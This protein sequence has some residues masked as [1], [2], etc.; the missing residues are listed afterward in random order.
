VNRPAARWE[1]S[2]NCTV[3]SGRNEDNPVNVGLG[4]MA[5]AR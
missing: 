4:H 1:N 5:H 2:K 3:N